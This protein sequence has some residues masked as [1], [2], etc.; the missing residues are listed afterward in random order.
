MLP[1]L[2]QQF[3]V[4]NKAKIVVA[5]E[6][7]GN[8]NLIASCPKTILI[9]LTSLKE[10]GVLFHRMVNLLGMH[11]LT[12][13]YMPDAKNGLDIQNHF[14]PVL[15]KLLMSDFNIIGCM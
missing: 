12:I 6:G 3:N 8:V 13:P 5:P 15:E 1:S 10:I 4:F 2:S 11:Y 14:L 9:E 7:A